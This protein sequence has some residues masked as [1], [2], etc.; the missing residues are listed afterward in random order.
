VGT[1]AIPA[2]SVPDWPGKRLRRRNLLC[3][4]LRKRSLTEGVA[5]ISL[6]MM[7]A[8]SNYAAESAPNG[9]F[10]AR[11]GDRTRETILTKADSGTTVDLRVGETL[12]VRLEESPTTGFGWMAEGGDDKLVL[13][14]S[15][16]SPA[17][18]G[19]G[20]G[21]L[22]SLTFIAAKVGMARL[23]LRLWREWEG[24]SSV[25]EVFTAGARINER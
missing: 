19:V 16:Y 12:L 2:A 1:C 7:V 5:V 18:V 24:D 10:A 14:A 15:D 25:V 11:E 23:K 22:R 17:S 20:G 4:D 3:S 21:G 6:A 13:Q 8:L 9:L